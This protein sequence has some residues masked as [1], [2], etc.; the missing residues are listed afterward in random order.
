MAEQQGHKRS[1]ILSVWI[2]EDDSRYRE[3]IT[4]LLDETHDMECTNTFN[5]IQNLLDVLRNAGKQKHPDVLLLDIHL[6]DKT[7]IAALPDIREIAPELQ[8][9]IL[10]IAED[11]SLIYNAFRNGANGYLIKDTPVDQLLQAIRE[12]SRGSTLM[13]PT[14]AEKVLEYFQKEQPETSESD[15]YGLTDREKEVLQ[16]MVEGL[17]QK[18]IAAKLNISPHTANSHIQNIYRKLQVNSGIKAVAKAVRE[19]LI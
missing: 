4:L 11:T 16:Q 8:V 18:E 17:S 13:P 10:T 7:G 14:V 3:S 12:A 6:P 15:S 19:K 9:V 2:V 1:E 5:S